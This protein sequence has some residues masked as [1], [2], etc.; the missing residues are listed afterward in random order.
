[1]FWESHQIDTSIYL[2]A[3]R[4][5]PGRLSENCKQMCLISGFST[6]AADFLFSL[7]FFDCFFALL[8]I[9]RPMQK[10]QSITW[11]ELLAIF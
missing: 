6:C 9:V 3:S 1:M 7:I 11:T 4:I 5:P 8:T 10:K 2:I